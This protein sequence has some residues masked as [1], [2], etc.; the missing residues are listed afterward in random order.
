MDKESVMK[1]FLKRKQSA[2][3]AFGITA[4]LALWLLSGTGA[5]GSA[6]DPSP[7]S[8]R[9]DRPAVT[10]VTVRTVAAE[11]VTRDVIIYGKTEAA[12]GATL[13]AE[14]D[15]RV[16]AIGAKRGAQVREGEMIVRLD[17]EAILGI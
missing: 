15:G 5:T 17:V 12:R 8:P 2:F 16:V 7:E 3:V 9:V 4:A 10:R 6:R 14:I 13:R 11:P 1:R